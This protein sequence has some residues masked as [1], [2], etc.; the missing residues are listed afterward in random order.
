MCT[1][2]LPP[3]VNPIA[4]NKYI[5]INPNASSLRSSHSAPVKLH[6]RFHTLFVVI[7]KMFTLVF[8]F[9]TL[10]IPGR[11][12]HNISTHLTFRGSYTAIYSY[13]KSQQVA[14]FLGFILV[15][16]LYMFRTDL[17]SISRSLNTVF[18]AKGFCHTGYVD[19]LLARSVHPDLASRQST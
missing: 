19:C 14:V 12:S 5:N 9:I 10:N 6:K 11:R 8:V 3:G 13:N 15:K 1:V 18:T 17:L 16:E 7:K 2:L 4:A